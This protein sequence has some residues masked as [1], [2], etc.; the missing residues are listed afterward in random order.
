MTLFK[1]AFDKFIDVIEIL[2]II[3]IFADLIIRDYSNPIVNLLH[4]VTEP[5]LEPIREL[6]RKTGLN[7]GMIDFSP[8]FAFLL[9][10]LVRRIV[11][12]L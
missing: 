8:L 10:N 1:I 11:F 5:I 7:T 3:R 6:I 9:L 4:Q 12:Y 2:I